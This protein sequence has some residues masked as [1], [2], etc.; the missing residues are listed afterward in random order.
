MIEPMPFD[1]KKT[2]TIQR[3]KHRTTSAIFRPT[4]QRKPEYDAVH[5]VVSEFLS[6]TMAR[7]FVSFVCL[8][9]STDVHWVQSVD[10]V[11]KEREGAFFFSISTS[12]ESEVDVVHCRY[13]WCCCW[14]CFDYFFHDCC[15]GCF[16]VDSYTLRIDILGSSLN[17][18]FHLFATIINHFI[19]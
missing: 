14:D 2:E 16:F 17:W 3:A 11:G 6:W 18:H 1:E 15:Y 8:D 19:I 9:S 13:W 5:N 12:A 10:R 7:L 4:T